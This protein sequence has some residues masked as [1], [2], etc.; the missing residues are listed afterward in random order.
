MGRGRTASPSTARGRTAS[1]RTLPRGWTRRRGCGRR[2]AFRRRGLGRP[3]WVDAQRFAVRDHVRALPL[4]APGTEDQVLDAVENLRRQRLDPA[5][6]LWQVWLLTGLDDGARC[7]LYLRVHHALGPGRPHPHLVHAA[8]DHLGRGT[9]TGQR[10]LDSV[11]AGLRPRRFASLP[12]PSV[13]PDVTTPVAA[14]PARRPTRRRVTQHGHQP[15]AGPGPRRDPTRPH[16]PPRMGH[17]R[18]SAPSADLGRLGIRRRPPNAGS[19]LGVL[20]TAW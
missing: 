13:P 15:R 16:G 5:L 20:T 7:A 17:P 9:A 1:G 8:G 4:P 18:I 3:L 2:C 11:R 14:T 6:P 10:P 19:S 12:T